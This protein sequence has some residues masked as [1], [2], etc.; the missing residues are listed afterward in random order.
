MAGKDNDSE[1]FDLFV[2]GGGVNGCGIARDAAGR[3]LKVALAEMSDLGSATSSASTKLFHGGL[4]YLEY[5]EFGLVKKA[6][7]EREI[8]L[9]AM[10]HISRPM[11]FVL[12]LSRDMRFDATTP[13]SRLLG[14]VMPWL[15]GRRPNWLIRLGLLFYDSMGGRRYLPGA[16]GLDLRKD[17]AGQLLQDKYRR[18][19]EYSDCVVDDSRLVVLNACDAARRGAVIMVQTRVVRAT[20]QGD[21]WEIETHSAET[22]AT[23]MHKARV[24]INASGPWVEQVINEPLGAASPAEIRLVKGSHIIVPKLFDHGRAYYLQGRDG[25]L[26]FAIPFEQDFTLIGTTETTHGGPDE[27]AS[28][29]DDE[30]AYLRMFVASYFKKPVEKADIIWTFSGVRPLLDEDAGSA[31]SATRDYQLVLNA[32]GGAPVL[33][34]FGGKI[35]TYRVLAQTVME[36][37]SGYFAALPDNWTASACLPGGDFPV[38]GVGALE[39]SLRAEFSFLDTCWAARLIQAYGTDAAKMLAGA[40]GLADLGRNFGAGLFEREVTWMI[41]HEFARN[42]QDIIWRRS[43]LGLR[44]SANEIAALEEW[45]QGHLTQIKTETD[46]G[47]G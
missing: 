29:S 3:G 12:P 1:I 23:A 26:V 35:T 4:R 42:A 21:L 10:P 6:L 40:T 2:I 7:V 31:T 8:L 47:N 44:L 22:G 45:V 15:K 16:K 41:E 13:T 28:I 37:I 39:A 9:A 27:P 32:D 33:H 36:Q 20:R 38:D 14:A 18:A 19:Y 46:H 34:V 25:R 11:R 5:F 43:K 24:L 30:I 17:P